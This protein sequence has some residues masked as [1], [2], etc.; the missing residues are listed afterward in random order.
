MIG[1][2]AYPIVGI[3]PASFSATSTD[4]WLPAK[5]SPWLLGQREARFLNGVGRLRPGVTIWTRDKK[6]LS[7][8]SR[9]SLASS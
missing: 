4:V 8:I 9:L 5:T 7:A 3:M 1:G 2:K 6:L